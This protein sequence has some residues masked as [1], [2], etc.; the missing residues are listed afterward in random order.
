[1]A[2]VKVNFDARKAFKEV[3]QAFRSV[4]R[5]KQFQKE[6]GE[7]LVKRIQGETRRG[8]PYNKE[9]SFPG[10]KSSTIKG[11]DNLS[12]F[13]KTHP[14]YSKARSN[15]TLTGQLVDSIKFKVKL[16]LYT[17]FPKGRRRPYRTG[18]NS[19]A[20][21]T[22]S[23]E[24]LSGFLS[25]KGFDLFDDGVLSNDRK[26]TKR[27]NNIFRRFLRRALRVRSRLNR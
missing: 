3:S 2:K 27:V 14:S 7:F 19:V 12:R 20:K 26:V 8:K 9:R 1:M 6:V 13:N 4:R 24:T 17:I 23:N 22:P 15:L 25:K 21:G 16:G 18:K 11:R 10:L 5:S